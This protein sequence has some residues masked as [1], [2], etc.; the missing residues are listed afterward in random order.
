[1]LATELANQ[2]V[3]IVEPYSTT[4]IGPTPTPDPE[5]TP[6]PEPTP[7]PTENESE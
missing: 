6:D 4:D 2:Q 3:N 1:M 7:E 5:L